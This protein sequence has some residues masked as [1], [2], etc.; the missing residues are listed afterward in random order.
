[1]IRESAWAGV[2]LAFRLPRVFLG[3]GVWLSLRRSRRSLARLD[4]RLLDDVGLTE[5]QVRHEM[6]RRL[7]DAPAH[8]FDRGARGH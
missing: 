4:A 2:R 6:A 8:W 7:W 5:E 3:L 1:M